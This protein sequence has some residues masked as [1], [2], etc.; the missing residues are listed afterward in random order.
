[1]LSYRL[2]KKPSVFVPK[3]MEVTDKMNTL[4]YHVICPFSVD[5]KSVI[6]NIMGPSVTQKNQI[7]S[8]KDTTTMTLL[9]MTILIT[10]K[11]GGITYNDIT[12][13]RFTYKSL[14]L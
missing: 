1:M 6:I 3:P 4:A 9:I 14:Y 13:N 10:L 7:R 2:R 8:I 12:F 11:T 5:Y